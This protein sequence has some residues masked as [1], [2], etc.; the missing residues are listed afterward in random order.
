[1]VLEIIFRL[2][3]QHFALMIISTVKEHH[4]RAANLWRLTLETWFRHQ[5][6]MFF[7]QNR[8]QE[9]PPTF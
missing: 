9:V 3:S 1:L 7:R 6:L 5:G 2:L 4:P 8:N